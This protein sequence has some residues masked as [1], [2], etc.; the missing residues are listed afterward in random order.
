M[1]T[2]TPPATVTPLTPAIYVLVW[3]PVVPMR[4][5]LASA[6]TPLLAMSMLL[7][8]VVSCETSRRAHS[9]IEA[10]RGVV[11]QRIYSD[12]DIGGAA[13]VAKQRT[14]PSSC[15]LAPGGII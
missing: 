2:P 11:K 1:I 8:P 12:G 9:D 5:V 13:C 15:V 14:Y 3:V 6:A 7:L 10:A 4:I